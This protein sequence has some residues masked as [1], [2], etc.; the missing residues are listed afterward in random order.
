LLLGVPSVRSKG[1]R[2]RGTVAKKGDRWYAVIYDGIDPVTGKDRR[3]WVP[4]GTRRSDADKLVE[5]PRVS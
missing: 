4:A 2:M 3:R 5:A 1:T